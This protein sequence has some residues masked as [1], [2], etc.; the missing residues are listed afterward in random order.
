M[1]EACIN[2]KYYFQSNKLNRVSIYGI[3]EYILRRGELRGCPVPV[4]K[5]HCKCE[6]YEPKKKAAFR[7]K[8][9]RHK[10]MEVCVDI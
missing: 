2:C 4:D 1:T 10:E 6:K 8:G 7:M 9:G 3:C 5:K